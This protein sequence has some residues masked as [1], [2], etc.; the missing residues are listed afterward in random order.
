MFE[1]FLF[2]VLRNKIKMLLDKENVNINKHCCGFII[3]TDIGATTT[4]VTGS[5]TSIAAIT[6]NISIN[7]IANTA[8][9]SPLPVLVQIPPAY[10]HD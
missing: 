6:I 3:I 8:L 4:D 9:I 5:A 7:I 1:P 10:Q 2:V